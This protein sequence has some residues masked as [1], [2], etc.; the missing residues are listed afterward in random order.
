MSLFY[1]CIICQHEHNTVIDLHNHHIQHHNL[2]ELSHT[3]ISLQG[4]KDWKNIKFKKKYFKSINLGDDNNN[5]NIYNH[6]FIKPKIKPQNKNMC[7]KKQKNSRKFSHDNITCSINCSQFIPWERELNKRKE[8]NDEEFINIIESLCYDLSKRKR[9]GRKKKDK[10]AIE[11]INSKDLMQHVE[12]IIEMENKSIDIKSGQTATTSFWNTKNSITNNTINNKFLTSQ[13]KNKIEDIKNNEITTLEL[14]N[15]K[16][17]EN[18]SKHYS[19]CNNISWNSIICMNVNEQEV[20]V[21]ETNVYPDSVK[22][23]IKNFL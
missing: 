13:N 9:R 16:K 4:Y 12:T 8:I 2:E 1:Q 19:S 6:L 15:I 10:T 22:I 21:E 20:L 3:I 7:K 23:D 11:K 14:V 18:V 5:E 17:N